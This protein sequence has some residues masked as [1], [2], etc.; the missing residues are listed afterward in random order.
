MLSIRYIEGRKIQ[1][2]DLRPY[3]SKERWS[4]SRD[5]GGDGTSADNCVLFTYFGCSLCYCA[6]EFEVV[7]CCVVMDSD[8][9]SDHFVMVLTQA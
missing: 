6:Y 3:M 4:G 8:L 5:M 2:N 7:S 9:E 1:H